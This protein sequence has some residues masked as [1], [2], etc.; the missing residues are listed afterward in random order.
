LWVYTVLRIENLGLIGEN[1]V[2]IVR[3]AVTRKRKRKFR[4]GRGQIKLRE[5]EKGG[6]IS[7]TSKQRAK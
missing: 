2:D 5:S 4:G 6:E 3:S 1:E 7:K